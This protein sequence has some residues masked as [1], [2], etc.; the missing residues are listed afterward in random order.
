MDGISTQQNTECF[1]LLSHFMLNFVI[2]ALWSLWVTLTPC[3][4]LIWLLRQWFLVVTVVT[5]STSSTKSLLTT[6]ISI[7][8]SSSPSRVILFLVIT[9]KLFPFKPFITISACLFIIP[10]RILPFWDCLCLSF[11]IISDPSLLFASRLVMM[12]FPAKRAFAT[13]SSRTWKKGSLSSRDP[14][15]WGP[16]PDIILTSLPLIFVSTTNSSK[17]SLYSSTSMG[18]TWK[19]G[20]LSSRDPDFWGPYPDIILTS[21]PLI[22][23]STTNSSKSSLYSSTSMGFRALWTPIIDPPEAYFLWTQII[24]N[25]FSLQFDFFIN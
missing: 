23:V 7:V 11:G 20:S 15:F 6:T 14:D 24:P 8:L 3:L 9:P 10:A 5:D 25:N 1:I 22:F 19:K 2:I 13:S 4:V 18:F 16:Y 21:L 17:S 12:D